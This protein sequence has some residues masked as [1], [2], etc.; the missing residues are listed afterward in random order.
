M[1]VRN[2]FVHDRDYIAIMPEDEVRGKV[3]Q[4]R[5]WIESDRRRGQDTHTLE[6]EYC[7][8][9]EELQLRETRKRAHAEFMRSNPQSF[10]EFY[11][12]VN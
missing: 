8:L 9:A 12:D 10:D 3:G 7:Y 11:Y 1:A 6:V 5:G 2:V 4:Y